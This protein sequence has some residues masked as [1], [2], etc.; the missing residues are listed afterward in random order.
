M[1]VPRRE[2]LCYFNLFHI[3][4]YL[5][6]VYVYI[7]TY[8]F[9]HIYIY[10]CI[11]FSMPPAAS[12]ISQHSW[13]CNALNLLE[14]MQR[15]HLQCDPISYSSAMVSGHLGF[16]AGKLHPLIGTRVPINPTGWKVKGQSM[17]GG[18]LSFWKGRTTKHIIEFTIVL[19]CFSQELGTVTTY[20]DDILQ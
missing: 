9:I 11:H 1:L 17:L 3:C 8:I 15:W 4:T 13:R 5:F 14:E 2:A 16:S 12:Q 10:V 6:T 18:F 19:R 20:L 7:Y